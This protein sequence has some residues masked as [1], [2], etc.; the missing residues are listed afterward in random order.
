MNSLLIFMISKMTYCSLLNLPTNQ[1][2][3]IHAQSDIELS[4]GE[5]V[6]YGILYVIDIGHP[7]ITADIGDIKQ[8]E[9]I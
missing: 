4:A 5:I 8:V 1:S 9:H 6:G 2:L 3:E 7:I